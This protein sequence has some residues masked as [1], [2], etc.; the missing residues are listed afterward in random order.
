M[1]KK[2]NIILYQRQKAHL[3]NYA[4]CSRFIVFIQAMGM[5]QSLMKP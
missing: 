2:F 1:Q 5:G 4:D 3:N